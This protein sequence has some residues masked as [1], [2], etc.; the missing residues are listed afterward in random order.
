MTRTLAAG[1]ARERPIEAVVRADAPFPVQ[2]D[3]VAATPFVRLVRLRGPAGSRRRFIVLAPHSGYAT[4][5]ISPLATALLTLGEVLVTDWIDGRMI[6]AS[7]GPFGLPEQVAV[8]LE[9]ADHMGSGGHLVAISQSGPAVLAAAAL[10]AASS[11][12]RAPASVVFL[13]CQLDPRVS[14][15]PLQQTLAHW[16]RE[17]L[18]AGLTCTVATDYPGSGRRVYPSLLQLLAYGMASPGLYAEV[19]QGLLRELAV[20][21][22]GEFDRQHADI[23]SL[24]DVPAELFVHMLGWALDGSPWKRDM[25]VLAGTSYDIS[26]LRAIPVL[27][28][29][30]GGDELVGAG[31]THA[32][33]T[34]L[35][36]DATLHR[37]ESAPSR[38][39]H[40][41]RL[42]QSGGTPAS[43]LLPRDR[44]L[45]P[46]SRV[47]T[48]PAPASHCGYR[49]PACRRA[50]SSP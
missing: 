30:A 33:G 32:L 8:G 12:E 44:R 18:H 42:C 9:A 7:A 6:P 17:M 15:T 34:R 10:L 29:E 43:P 48:L 3:L 27:T 20:G 14:P 37:A 49:V 2:D 31:Q 23:H 50:R 16:P 22:T 36:T 41:P 19:Q 26:P 4:A 39:V 46:L 35:R 24:L 28:L 1:A 13:G 11:A 47:V 40:G 21:R 5:V 25:P 45:K 38:P